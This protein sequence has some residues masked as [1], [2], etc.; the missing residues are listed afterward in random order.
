[1]KAPLFKE[2]E[3]LIIEYNKCDVTALRKVHR[4]SEVEIINSA[5]WYRWVGEGNISGRYSFIHLFRK[6]FR[7]YPL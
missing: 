7:E 5:R 6:I 3:T 2:V 1:M 4:N